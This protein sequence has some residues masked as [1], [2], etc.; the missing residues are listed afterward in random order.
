[1][2]IDQPGTFCNMGSV[3]GQSV[4]EGNGRRTDQNENI[5]ELTCITSSCRAFPKRHHPLSAISTLHLPSTANMQFSTFIVLATAAL[6][7][8]SP[9]DKCTSAYNKC[10]KTQSSLTFMSTCTLNF[11]TCSAFGGLEIANDS[12]NQPTSMTTDQKTVYTKCKKE[13]D[14]CRVVPGANLSTCASEVVV[15]FQGTQTKMEE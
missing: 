9:I 6:I 13:Y 10:Q 3:I 12:L 15:C 5:N 7:T 14:A 4:D 11:A 2:Q 8:A 1:M